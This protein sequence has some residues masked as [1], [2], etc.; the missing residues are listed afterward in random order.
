MIFKVPMIITAICFVAVVVTSMVIHI[1]LAPTVNYCT[2]L[3]VYIIGCIFFSFLNFFVTILS[4]YWKSWF[5]PKDDSD[6]KDDKS[7]N[8][9]N[10]MPRIMYSVL[11]ISVLVF[12]LIC[13]LVYCITAGD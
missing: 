2:T 11:R 1:I 13:L 3:D 12:Y 4:G 6:P 10:G 7:E 8:N 9:I 5:T